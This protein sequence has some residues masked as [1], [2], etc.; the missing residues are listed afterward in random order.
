[1]DT[2][3]YLDSC[4]RDAEQKEEARKQRMDAILTPVI[5]FCFWV[6]LIGAWMLK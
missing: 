2:R 4:R 1:M 3:A 6:V 5:C